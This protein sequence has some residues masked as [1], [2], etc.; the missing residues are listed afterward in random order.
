MREFDEIKERQAYLKQS[1]VS[2]MDRTERAIIEA[3]I[4]EIDLVLMPSARELEGIEN[5]RLI[6]EA[7]AQHIL[8]YGNNYSRFRSWYCETHQVSVAGRVADHLKEQHSE[9]VQKIQENRQ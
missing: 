2:S 6:N 5:E 3:R 7:V 1:L 9:W 8:G 4:D